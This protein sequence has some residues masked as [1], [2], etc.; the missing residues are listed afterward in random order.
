MRLMVVGFMFCIGGDL[1]FW[2]VCL[3]CFGFACLGLEFVGWVLGCVLGWVLGWVL[4]GFLC[5]IGFGGCFVWVGECGGLYWCVVCGVCGVGCRAVGPVPPFRR[6]IT[7]VGLLGGLVG[8]CC[9]GCGFDLD[10]LILVLGL[11][12]LGVL[13]LCG[14]GII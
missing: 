8:C 12:D 4:F 11:L 14:V 6:V 9:L 5:G 10:F 7:I 1:W 13:G 3:C 2:C